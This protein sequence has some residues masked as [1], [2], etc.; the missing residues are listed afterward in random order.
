MNKEYNFNDNSDLDDK[1]DLFN[2][3]ATLTKLYTDKTHLIYELLQNAEDCRAKCVKFFMYP[4]RLEM[5]HDGEPFNAENLTSVRSVNQSTKADKLNA[6]GKFGVGFKAVFCI[7]ETVE[8]YNEPQNYSGVGSE[9]LPR[10][11]IRIDDFRTMRKIAFDKEFASPFTTCFV[12]PFAVARDG[13]EFLGYSD[14]DSLRHTLSSKLRTLGADAMLFLKNII[15]ISYEIDDTDKKH[16]QGTYLLDKEDI[17][18]DVLKITTLGGIDG[19]AEEAAY[20]KYSAVAPD[21]NGKTVDLVFAVKWSDDTIEFIKPN[22][23]HRH[24]FVYFPTETESKLN[25]IVQAPFMTTPNRES[26]PSTEEDNVSLAEI[27]ADLLEKA[28]LDIRARGWLTLNFL[29]L[30][31]IGEAYPSD[32]LFK[33]LQGKTNEMFKTLEI[34]P[35]IDGGFTTAKNANIAYTSKLAEIFNGSTLGKLL[36]NSAAVWLPTTLT[37]YGELTN[38]WGY[39]TGPNSINIPARRPE[40]ISDLLSRKPINLI[41]RKPNFFDKSLS[42]EWLIDFY[43]Y[44]ADRERPVKEKFKDIRFIKTERGSFVRPDSAK[45]FTRPKNDIDY[46][47]DFVFAAGFISEKCE[48]LLEFFRIMPPNEYVLLEKEMN[49]YNDEKEI[50]HDKS[51]RHLK[52]ALR[53]LSK[54][55]AADFFKEKLWLK[56]TDPDGEDSWVTPS[57]TIYFSEDKNGIPLRDYFDGIDSDM[58]F[59]DESYY[60]SKG[61]SESDLSK[62]IAIGV[63]NSIYICDDEISWNDGNAKCS[64][65]G[66]FKRRLTILKL[67]EALDFIDKDAGDSAKAKS[68]LIFNLLLNVQNRLKGRWKKSVMSNSED[69][70]ADIVKI[71]REREWL[72]SNDEFL[73]MPSEI[74]RYDL[75][76]ELYGAVDETCEIYDILGFT[77][78]EADDFEDISLKIDNL[79]QAQKEALL[80]K[81]AESEQE[82]DSDFVFE[83]VNEIQNFPIRKVENPALLKRKVMNDYKTAPEAKYEYKLRH[84]RTSQNT[85]TDKKYIYWIYGGYCQMCEKHRGYWRMCALFLKPKK[86]LKQLN[87]S[88][89]P[90]CA[91]KYIKLRYDND[92]MDIFANDLLEADINGSL[93]ITLDDC[94][95]RFTKTHLAEIQEILRLQGEEEE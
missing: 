8:V 75:D 57:F 14:M 52:A 34:L 41:N 12:F 35:T 21:T 78:T 87:L 81:L 46:A 1:K 27:A 10:F 31:P 42:D 91:A 48:S 69:D 15:E 2:A 22:E 93:R 23:K 62:L 77:K 60:E 92:T 56:C 49:E 64:N 16:K 3:I 26:V 58:Y 32:W 7:C 80:N 5:W 72:F 36:N 82:E 68:G 20:I 38:L 85:L 40:Q 73:Y 39:L 86:E 24:I 47:D 4:D 55:G 17:G 25:F 30:M 44:I 28:V 79:T 59:L 18:N 90:N 76:T 83:D 74:S 66:D 43:N 6:I 37:K 84:V 70:V 88:F 95:I 11:A 29:S 71:L 54:D 19:K 63:R 53:F 9:H 94:E 65:L 33:P 89:C 61:V 45:L 13:K 50:D 51:L 67:R